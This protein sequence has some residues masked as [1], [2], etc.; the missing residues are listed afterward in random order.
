MKVSFLKI[1]LSPTLSCDFLLLFLILTYDGYLLT[2]AALYNS[3]LP[4]VSNMVIA[5]IEV[6]VC[7]ITLYDQK[8][9]CRSD[10]LLEI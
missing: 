1:G 5:D 10:L 6:T 8:N 7:I 4:L 3:H 9:C 2:I